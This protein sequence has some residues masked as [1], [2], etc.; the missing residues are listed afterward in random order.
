MCC[1]ICMLMTDRKMGTVRMQMVEREE[2]NRGR[3]M[4][5]GEW[6]WGKVVEVRGNGRERRPRRC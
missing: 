2:V 4:Q 5:M 6:W 1:C 3:V